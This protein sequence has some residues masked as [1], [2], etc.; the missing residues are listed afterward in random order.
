MF[1]VDER[2]LAD[3]YDEFAREV[4]LSDKITK[5]VE[6]QEGRTVELPPMELRKQMSEELQKEIDNM[7]EQDLLDRMNEIRKDELAYEGIRKNNTQYRSLIYSKGMMRERYT[8]SYKDGSDNVK[9]YDDINDIVL[10]R[11][12]VYV[13]SN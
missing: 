12:L 4:R 11:Y 3:S 9:D 13:F 8:S 5:E 10:D 2:V 6:G 1:F 7:S